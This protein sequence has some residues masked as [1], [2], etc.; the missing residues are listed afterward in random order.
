MGKSLIWSEDMDY[1]LGWARDFEDEQD[2]VETVKSQYEETEDHECVV[3]AVLR[4][5]C[6]VT[7]KGLRPE[8][9]TPV[10]IADV[11]MEEFYTAKVEPMEE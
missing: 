7:E 6:F 1:V 2:F 10:R 9:I 3:T 11:T 4:E 8:T 5:L